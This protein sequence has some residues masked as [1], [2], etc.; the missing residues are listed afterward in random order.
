[1]RSYLIVIVSVLTLAVALSQPV[2]AQ[3]TTGNPSKGTARQFGTGQKTTGTVGSPSRGT[4]RGIT[5]GGGTGGGGGGNAPLPGTISLDLAGNNTVILHCTLI[6]AGTFTMGSP[7]TEVGHEAE[8]EPL[9]QVTITKDYYSGTTEVT[10]IQFITIMSTN[11]SNFQPPVV[12]AV[13]LGFDYRFLPVES[14]WHTDNRPGV[15]HVDAQLFCQRLGTKVVRRVRLPTEAE[16]EFAVRGG[17]QTAY[18][19]GAAPAPLP[20]HAWIAANSG[21]VTHLT[22][23]VPPSGLSPANV[24]NKRPNPRG[25]HDV[26][27]NVWEWCSD[28]YGAYVAGA[29]TDPTGPRSGDYRVIRGGAYNSVAATDCRSANRWWAWPDDPAL[30]P[31]PWPNPAPSIWTIPPWP[32]PNTDYTTIGFRVVVEAP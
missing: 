6:R 4:A 5:T 22:V 27:G 16:W 20:D 14:V 29:A 3:G 21:G 24:N 28:W 1:M 11:P 8:E 15:T 18:Y 26:Y 23:D 17:T 7:V 2:L 25:L 12:P 9:H 10:Q 13:I 32:L 19:F 31:L 30:H